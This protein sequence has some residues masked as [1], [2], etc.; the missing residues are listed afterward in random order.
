[1]LAA[2]LT[3]VLKGEAEN[4]KRRERLVSEFPG[5][6]WVASFAA[7]VKAPRVG[8]EPIINQLAAD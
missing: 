6:S 5:N 4:A 8:F 1:M 7:I 2:R 3:E